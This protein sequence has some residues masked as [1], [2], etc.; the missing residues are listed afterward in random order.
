MSN[1]FKSV[2]VK[3]ALMPDTHS[4]TTATSFAHIREW[5]RAGGGGVEGLLHTPKIY[6]LKPHKAAIRRGDN[7]DGITL[8]THQW[9][10]SHGLWKSLIYSRINS[11]LLDLLLLLLLNYILTLW[12]KKKLVMNADR[13]HIAPLSGLFVSFIHSR[14]VVIDLKPTP[15]LI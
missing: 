15:P 14:L 3:C 2:S 7:S 1:Y 10:M 13:L 6:I 4:P 8:Y 12:Q 9:T 5:R 11:F